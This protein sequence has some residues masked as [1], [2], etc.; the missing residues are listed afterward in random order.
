MS[1][2]CR[3]RGY[4]TTRERVNNRSKHK[5]WC[6]GGDSNSHELALTTPSRWRVYLFHHLGM[7]GRRRGR[8]PKPHA[9]AVLQVWRGHHHSLRSL[10]VSR[11]PLLMSPENPATLAVPAPSADSKRVWWAHEGAPRPGLG[12]GRYGEASGS[13]IV[14]GQHW[15]AAPGQGHGRSIAP[16]MPL[17][18]TTQGILSRSAAVPRHRRWRRPGPP[19]RPPPTPSLLQSGHTHCRFLHFALPCRV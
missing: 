11:N 13:A 19:S 14:S 3:Q 4:S 18:C 1:A 12:C 5:K 7:K 8:A 9:R 6:R 2:E 15:S 16:S 10:S 17:G